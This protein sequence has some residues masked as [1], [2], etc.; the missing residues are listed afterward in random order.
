MDITLIMDIVLIM[1]YNNTSDYNTYHGD[2]ILRTITYRIVSCPN[3]V[4]KKYR[5]LHPKC[6]AAVH[7]VNVK[8][9]RG[10]Q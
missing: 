2:T 8:G 7:K 1:N 9:R 4:R 5:S 10:F 6:T 3:Q